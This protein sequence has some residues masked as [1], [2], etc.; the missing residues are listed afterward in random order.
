MNDAVDYK[1]AFGKTARTILYEDTFGEILFAFDT[2]PAKDETTGKWRLYLDN[3]PMID[4]KS[5]E[6]KTEAE[7][8]RV[9]V[10]LERTRRYAE[11]SGYL[12][13]FS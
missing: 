9:A 2:S 8:Q 7:R 6:P 10:A 1:V 5:F 12:V 11:S 3:R 13:E 4:R